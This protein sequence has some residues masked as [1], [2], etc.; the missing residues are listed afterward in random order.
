MSNGDS[1]FQEEKIWPNR[2]QLSRYVI[3]FGVIPSTRPRLVINVLKPQVRRCD[4]GTSQL[5]MA[6]FRKHIGI[7]FALN[8]ENEF[9]DQ[10][11]TEFAFIPNNG[12]KLYFLP[13]GKVFSVHPV[14][15]QKVIRVYF[16]SF[17]TLT[18]GEAGR[19]DWRHGRFPPEGG[20]LRRSGHLGLKKNLLPLPE[21][22]QQF[23]C[24]AAFSLF[25]VLENAQ[26]LALLLN[27]F[28]TFGTTVTRDPEL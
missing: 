26:G 8:E 5:G 15:T 21:I 19:S 12:S 20:S 6:Q 16:L 22:K 17:L 9:P 24:R 13:I 11:Q 2:W 4:T 3:K 7:V 10:K 28:C 18:V 23:L 14:K 1:H 27:D 25:I